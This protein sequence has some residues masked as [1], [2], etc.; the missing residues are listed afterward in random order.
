MR[1][2]K[3]RPEEKMAGILDDLDIK[4]EREFTPFEGLRK[5]R[6]DFLVPSLN[7][8]I[9]VEG[10]AFSGG[11]HTRGYGFDADCEK[12]NSITA[13]GLRVFRFTGKQINY[14][15]AKKFIQSLKEGNLWIV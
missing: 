5:W 2:R 14:G 1:N 12:Y 4:Y 11:R 10:G 7:A 9:E 8:V 3:S 15:Y 6:C 13:L